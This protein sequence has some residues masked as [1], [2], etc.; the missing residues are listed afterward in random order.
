[1]PLGALRG[2]LLHEVGGVLDVGHYAR[3]TVLLWL[4]WFMIS[5]GH[6]GA[7]P[8]FPSWFRAKGFALPAVYPNV[9]IPP[10]K[11]KHVVAV[12]YSFNCNVSIFLS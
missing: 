11:R 4:V 5:I 12:S 1:M 10:R 9:F 2:Y 3:A 8:W 6:S 7:F